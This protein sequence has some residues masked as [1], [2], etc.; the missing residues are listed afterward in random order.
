MLE[1]P[2]AVRVDSYARAYTWSSVFAS[3]Q[4]YMVDVRFLEGMRCRQTRDASADDDDLEDFLLLRV[5]FYSA[6][7]VLRMRAGVCAY[8]YFDWYTLPIFVHGGWRVE[9]CPI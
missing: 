7:C 1:Q 2:R 4:N 5:V 6:R 8:A 9:A 3:L